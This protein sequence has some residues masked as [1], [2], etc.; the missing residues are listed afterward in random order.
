MQA[1]REHTQQRTVQ[2]LPRRDLW[3][4]ILFYT[5][6]EMVRRALPS[7]TPYATTNGLWKRAWPMYVA[8][9]ERDWR[10]Y[11]DAKVSFDPAI[12]AIVKDVG[13]PKQ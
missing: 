3:H 6:G 4:A 5:T 2:L 11:L 7:Y 1:G 8:P 13:I 9:L 10:P 12:S